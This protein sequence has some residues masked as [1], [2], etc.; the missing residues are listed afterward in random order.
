MREEIFGPILPVVDYA[1]IDDAVAFIQSRERPLAL[2][3]FTH[4]GA[5]RERVLGNTIS[6]GVTVNDWAWHVFNHDAPFGGVGNSGMGNY[7]GADGF[8]ELS[9]AKTVF[10]K[11]RLFPVDLFYPP[12]GSAVQRMILRLFVGKAEDGANTAAGQATKPGINDVD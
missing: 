7:H 4:D 12:Y 5:V 6:G 9:H 8:R 2:Y 10:M 3:C 1:N 11:H